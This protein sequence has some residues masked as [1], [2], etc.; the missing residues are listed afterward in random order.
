M[1][2]VVDID[3]VLADATHREHFVQQQPPDWERFFDAV[4]A[5]PVIERGRDLVSELAIVHEIV[6]LSG[7]PERTRSDTEEW[8]REHRIPYGQLV[9]RPDHDRRPAATLK[10]DLIRRLGGR[11]AIAVVV[12][13]DPA[14]VSRLAAA[15][16]ETYRFV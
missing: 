12:D 4:G 10:G 5:D 7:R 8:L 6:L 13:D 15:G 3:G 2:A 1:I 16:Y 11:D 14:V 9:L